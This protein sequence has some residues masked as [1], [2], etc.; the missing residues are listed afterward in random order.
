MPVNPFVGRRPHPV[1]LVPRRFLR[2][3]PVVSADSFWNYAWSSHSETLRGDFNY[4]IAR[5]VDRWTK[6]RMARQNPDLVATFLRE[7]EQQEHEP[8]P[9]DDPRLRLTWWEKGAEIAQRSVIAQPVTESAQ[10]A[11]FVRNLVGVFQHGIE[12]Q[13][14]WT[15]LWH[16]GVSLPEKKVQAL[17]RSCVVHYCRA[18][19]VD[20]SGEPNAGRGPVDFKFSQGWSARAL[21]EIKLMR[22]TGFWDGILAQTPQYALSEEVKVGFFVAVAYKDEEMDHERVAKVEHAAK[23]VAA[24]TSVYVVPV[25]IDARPKDSASKLKAPKSTK[26]RLHRRD[27]DN[28]PEDYSLAA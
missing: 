26:E 3:I 2:D 1:L 27:G 25:I 24:E 10:F 20:V 16:Q 17:F 21:V 19:N 18:N 11:D 13:G 23:L 4:D 8:Y 9:V 5:N 28:E 15:M 12:H 14:D 22:N 7:M 6:A